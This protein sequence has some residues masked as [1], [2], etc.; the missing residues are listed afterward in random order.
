MLWAQ[1]IGLRIGPSFGLSLG[2][3]FSKSIELPPR[4]ARTPP[5]TNSARS[6]ASNSSGAI[7]LTMK[8][9]M[10]HCTVSSG[11]N[12]LAPRSPKGQTG[13]GH[14]EEI[15]IRERIKARVGKRIKAKE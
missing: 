15:R 8:I 9:M 4:R 14:K 1:Y 5:P 13:R 11:K 10:R 3:R 6:R 12:I 2:L 7:T